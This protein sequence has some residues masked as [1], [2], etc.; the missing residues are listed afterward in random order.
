MPGMSVLEPRAVTAGRAAAQEESNTPHLQPVPQRKG[1]DEV[2]HQAVLAHQALQQGA[3][4]GQQGH[5]RIVQVPLLLQGSRSANFQYKYFGFDFSDNIL[6]S[7]AGGKH[8]GWEAAAVVA[9]ERTAQALGRA[10]GRG[11][12]R[13]AGGSRQQRHAVLEALEAKGMQQRAG[14]AAATGCGGQPP[15]ECSMR[16]HQKPIP[17][18]TQRR[19]RSMGG[20]AFQTGGPWLDC[21]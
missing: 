12:Q 17:V 13:Q 20:S 11:R 6:L 9:A 10:A 18:P 15:T 14:Q 1:G 8:S 19:M 7:G 16:C 3:H 5:R 21:G 2:V 4:H